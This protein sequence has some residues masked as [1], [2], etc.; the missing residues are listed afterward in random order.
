MSPP[1]TGT[2]AETYCA[3][4][5]HTVTSLRCGQC[6]RPICPRC[7]VLTPVGAKCAECARAR[8]LPTFELT[9]LTALAAGCSA[10]ALA[11][12]LGAFGS[13]L[14]R[15][16][17][18]LVIAFPFGVGLILAEV[19]SRVANRKRHPLLRILVGAGVALS[20]L[21]LTLGDFIVHGPIEFARSGL[22][23][24]L[25]LNVLVGLVENPFVLL[26]ILVGIWVGVTRVG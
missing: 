11:I 10:L 5:P 6:Q 26:F 9:P 13:L 4:H 7:L 24:P 19:V 16:L 15:F 8:R 1:E 23:G 17:P 18:M 14:L 21:V 25:L 22:I 2:G 20:Y 3:R 12:A